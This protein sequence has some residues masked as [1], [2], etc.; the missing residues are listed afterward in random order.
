MPVSIAG[1]TAKQLREER[2]TI[3]KQQQ[4]K[5]DER[6][7]S[8][9]ASD[10]E[11]YDVAMDD[12][13]RL[14]RAANQRE[15]LGGLISG[16]TGGGGSDPPRPDPMGMHGDDGGNRQPETIQLRSGYTDRGQPRY[17]SVPAGGLGQPE[18]QKAFADFLRTGKPSA[19]LQSDDSEQAGYLV[20]SEQFAAGIL[21]EVD[22]LLFVRRYARI[23]TVREATS[24]GIRART[25]RAATFDW[26]AELE[27]SDEDTALKY[28]KRV[29]EPHHLTGQIK[30][31]RDLLRRSVV[32]V[33]GEVMSEMA[34][35][36]G[37]VMEDG[38]LTGNGARQPLGVF[39]PSAD[40]ISTSRDVL[41]GSATTFLPDQL[42]AAK[43][44]LKGQYRRGQLGEVRWLFHRD[45]ISLIARL[46]DTANQYLFRVGAGRQQD[47]Q[48][49]EDM[50]LGFPVDESERCPNTF[51]D[52]NYVGLLANWRYY[53]IADALSMEMQVL[54]ELHAA[55]NQV[56]YIGRLKTDGMPTLQEAFVRL[57]TGTL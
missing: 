20:A 14:L 57:K 8:W 44:S 41:T 18:Y 16:S 5:L 28:G 30:V 19:A 4:A 45:A 31:S 9:D 10:D 2:A 32:S 39:T 27:V 33:E 12:A 37:E 21:K 17:V 43:Y 25:S 52:G 36:A 7:D 55:T 42:L 15:T 24:L 56:G 50:L 53:E 49:P 47:N 23:H 6:G 26:S 34:R 48:P 3:I 13:E 35:D 22:D 11:A 51:T 1:K 46:K 29:L 54:M 38:Y 40:G